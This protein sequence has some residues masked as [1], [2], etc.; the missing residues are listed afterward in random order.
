MNCLLIAATAKEIGPFLSYYRETPK[1]FHLDLSIDVLITGVGLTATTYQLS[2][3]LRIRRPDL[4]VQAGIAGCFDKK[5]A[6]GT[7]VAIKQEAIADEGV[8]EKDGFRNVFEL[9]LAGKNQFPYKKGWLVNPGEVLLK[10]TGLKS[11]RGISVNQVTTEK[12]A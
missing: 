8:M 2:R 3:H 12:K 5:L 6:N 7:V 1:M 4:V 11:V 10:R 9:G